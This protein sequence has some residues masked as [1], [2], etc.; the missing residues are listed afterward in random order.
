MEGSFFY[1]N[2]AMAAREKYSSLYS[3]DADILECTI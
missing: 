2:A 1:H 3:G